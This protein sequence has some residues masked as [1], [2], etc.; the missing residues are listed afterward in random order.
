MKTG[1][2]QLFETFYAQ[3]VKCQYRKS[4]QGL[5]YWVLKLLYEETVVEAFHWHTSGC[6]GLC[7]RDGDELLVC[8]VWTTEETGRMQ[9]LASQLTSRVAANDPLS[10]AL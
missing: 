10:G 4:T 6:S 3:V 8:G 5:R 9:I 7:Y 2:T 1:Q